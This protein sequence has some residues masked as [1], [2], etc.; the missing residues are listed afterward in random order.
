MSQLRRASVGKGKINLFEEQ[1]DRFAGAE[2]TVQD[3]NKIRKLQRAKLEPIESFW[4]YQTNGLAV[5][6]APA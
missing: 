2:H 4:H 3:E 5:L 1:F 6:R